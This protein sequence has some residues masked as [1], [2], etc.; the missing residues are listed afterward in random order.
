[1]KTETRPSGQLF[2]QFDYLQ[3]VASTNDYLKAF[4]VEGEP[5]M[6]VA[7]G[8]TAGKGRYSR[9]WHSPSGKGLYVSYL[10]YPEWHL[11][12]APFL[13]MLAGLAVVSAIREKAAST[14][15]IKLKRPNDV[16]IAGKKVCGIL[17]ETSSL[18][19]RILW[20]IIGIGVNLYQEDFP[21]DLRQKA[22][23]L[24]LEGLSVDHPLDFC[25][26]LTKQ[27][28]CLYRKLE[29]GAWELVQREFESQLVARS[30]AR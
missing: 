29:M 9:K 22:T 3:T 2:K 18:R 26:T 10:L 13:E 8:Q 15:Q 5:R 19:D 16:F 12:R 30:K 4:V 17:T 20:A 1:M 14:L 25:D 6:V 21:G 7:R 27:F 28:E 11:Q 23:S 24:A